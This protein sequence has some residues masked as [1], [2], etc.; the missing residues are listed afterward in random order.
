MN[1]ITRRS[2]IDHTTRGSLIK[3]FYFRRILKKIK[4][5]KKSETRMIASILKQDPNT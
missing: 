2:I 1:V 3:I 4:K 5:N